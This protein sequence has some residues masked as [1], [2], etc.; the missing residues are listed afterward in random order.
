MA[1][2]CHHGEDIG[3]GHLDGFVKVEGQRD[4]DGQLADVEERRREGRREETQL[5]LQHNQ[6]H[7]DPDADTRHRHRHR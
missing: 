7:P 4:V 6:V 5:V 2:Y 3:H 1:T